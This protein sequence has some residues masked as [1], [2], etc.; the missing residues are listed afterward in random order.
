VSLPRSKYFTPAEMRCRDEV[1]TPY[2]EQWALRLAVLFEALDTIREEWGG[3]LTIVSG[4]RTPEHNSE[5]N[6]AHQSQHVQGR[7]VDLRPLKRNLSVGDINR[8]GSIVE[9]LLAQAKL[10]AVGGVGVYPLHRDPR[11]N[12]LF[13]GW[14]HVDCRPRPAD[15]HIA[16]WQGEKFG[17]EKPSEVA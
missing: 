10:P 5:I 11:S 15:G 14:V 1:R 17:D 13:P 4:Y 16:R 7:A 9:M 3:P 12:L 6:G 8:L 2:P